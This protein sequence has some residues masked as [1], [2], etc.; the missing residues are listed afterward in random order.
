[1]LG[2][3]KKLVFNSGFMEASQA[4]SNLSYA[5]H[6]STLTH[7]VGD[8]DVDDDEELAEG[9]VEDNHLEVQVEGVTTRTDADLSAA[10]H[11][12]EEP[13]PDTEGPPRNR[14]RL[15]LPSSPL[16]SA[17]RGR[18]LSLGQSMVL[19]APPMGPSKMKVI[20]RDSSYWT[21][22]AM[23][24]YVRILRTYAG[25]II[26]LLVGRCTRT[27]LS[28]R[29]CRRLSSS[30]PSQTWSLSSRRR[31]R[32]SKPPQ[33][34]NVRHS[35]LQP[36]PPRAPTPVSRRD[37]RVGENGS[38]IGKSRTLEDLARVRPKLSIGLRIV[39]NSW[40]TDS[41]FLTSVRS[42]SIRTQEQSVPGNALVIRMCPDCRRIA[43][44]HIV[45]SL[46]TAN[47]AYEVF[48]TFSATYEEVR[49]VPSP[50]IGGGPSLIL[51]CL[52]A[53]D[54][55]L[56]RQLVRRSWLRSYAARL[57]ADSPWRTSWL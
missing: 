30:P 10:E 37:P 54:H 29:P 40:Y 12:S 47:I 24:N 13:D 38:K 28:L 2:H 19:P 14:P 32:Q 48:S 56:P 33:R 35:T 39:S 57:A 23:L 42:G 21:Y 31:R 25:R 15:S 52:L 7:T 50:F 9:D 34:K 43:S 16:L 44:Q 26:D 6:D 45:K 51:V 11:A 17:N 3:S 55:V 49:K 8:S 4:D 27:V 53:H 41:S 22:R 5:H 18:G 36:S 46:T 20:V 1:M